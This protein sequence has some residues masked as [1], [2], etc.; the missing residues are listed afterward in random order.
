MADFVTITTDGAG[1]ATL[2]LDR[3]PVNAIDRGVWD[4]LSAAARALAADGD[5]AAVVVW[6]G[7]K[8]FAAGA[9]IK[10]MRGWGLREGLAAAGGLQDAF[11]ALARLPQVTIAAINGYALGGGCELALTAD[12][13]YAADDARL[14]QPEVLLGLIPGGGGTQRLTRLVGVQKAKEM[15]YGGSFYS[16]RASLDMGLV[17]RV[18]APS[19]V[20]DAAVE[21]ARRYAAG[22]YALRLAKRAIDE[23]GQMTLDA[24]LRLETSLFASCFTTAD[25]RTGMASFLEQ[26]PGRA[27]F[28]RT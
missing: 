6:G 18:V 13:R 28:T 21:A 2:R 3:P 17:D 4:E 23:A 27:T 24:A 1:V 15:V 8:V 22:P 16:A 11:S 5:V 25:A 7:P 14:G 12:F 26:G 19:E 10:A 20:Y 9:D